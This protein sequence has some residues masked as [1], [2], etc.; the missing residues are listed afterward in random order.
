M[1]AQFH[2]QTTTKN[3][4]ERSGVSIDAYTKQ[5]QGMNISFT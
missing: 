4:T 1:K 5:E 2:K 3:S